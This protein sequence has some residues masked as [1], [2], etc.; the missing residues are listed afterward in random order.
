MFATQKI[1]NSTIVLISY[2]RGRFVKADFQTELDIKVR[3]HSAFHSSEINFIL[4]PYIYSC[5]FLSQGI[6]I[7]DVEGKRIL[8]SVMH[9]EKISH[10]YVSEANADMSEIK[11]VPSLENVF[12]YL[13]NLNWKSSWLV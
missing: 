9:T 13:P 12:T 4:Q 6:H 1:L 10:L 8:I 2:K 11:F 7:A 3:T 5:Y